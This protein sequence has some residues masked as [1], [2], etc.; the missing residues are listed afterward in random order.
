[1]KLL[2]GLRHWTP[3]ALLFGCLTPALLPAQTLDPSAPTQPPQNNAVGGKLSVDLMFTQAEA[4]GVTLRHGAVVPGSEEVSVDG[5]RLKRGDDYTIDNDAGIV[6]LLIPTKPGQAVSVNYR[7]DASR[8]HAGE[9]V[10]ASNLVPFRLDFGGNG[11]LGFTLGM[12][13]AERT[14]DGSVLSSNIFGWKNTF[15]V[16]GSNLSGLMLLGERTQQQARSNFEYQAQTTAPD[17]GKSHLII[18]SLRGNLGGG[19]YKL[20]FQDISKNFAG[21]SAVTANGYDS[22]LANQLSK[23]KG[24]KRFGFTMDKV[25]LGSLGLTESYRTVGNENGGITWKNFGINAGGLSM[26]YTSQAVDP[27][28]NRFQDLAEANHD[29]LAKEAGLTRQSMNAAWKLGFGSLTYD[30]SSIDDT[31]NDK[32]INRKDLKLTTPKFNFDL[33]SQS[34]QAGF[35]R[36]GSLNDP[37]A[38]QWGKESGL[39]RNWLSFDS[40]LGGANALKFMKYDINSPTGGMENVDASFTGKMWSF[41]HIKRDVDSGFSA[42]PN[43]TQQEINSNIGAITN[44]YVKGGLPVTPDMQ[45]LYMQSPGIDRD[46]TRMTFNPTPAWNIGFDTLKFRGK[47][48]DASVND[49][50][51]KGGGVN[52]TY[53]H[54]DFGPNFNELTHLMPFEQQRLGTMAGLQR[55]DF[56]FNADMRK[57]AKLAFSQTNASTANGGMDRQVLAYNDKTMQLNVNSRKVGPNFTTVGQLLDPEAAILSQMIGFRE[58]DAMLNWQVLSNLHIQASSWSGV[59]DA[60][61]QKRAASN[62]LVDWGPN[63]ATQFQFQHNSMDSNNPLDML[64]ANVLQRMSLTENLGKTGVLKYTQQDMQFDGTQTTQPDSKQSDLSY[65]TKLNATTSMKTEQI[66]TNYSDGNHENVS[67][68]TINTEL[69]KKA[70]LS[71]TDVAIQRTGTAPSE[72]KRNVGFWMNLWN[73]VRLNF[74]VND[75]LN[76]AGTSLTS[77][78]VSLSPGT[79]GNWNIGSATYLANTWQQGDRT[80]AQSNISLNTVKPFNIG[81]FDDL[82]LKMGQDTAADN[83]AWLKENKTLALAGKLGKNAFG[84]SYFGQMNNLHQRGADRLFTFSTDQSVTSRFVAS[85]SYKFRTLPGDQ[86]IAI[87]NFNITARPWN[88]LEICN[89]I[90]TNPEIPRGDVLLGSLPQPTRVNKWSLNYTRDPN[91]KVS[92]SWEEQRNDD[93]NGLT[94]LGGV[95]LTMFE[96]SGSPVSLF[97]GVEQAKGNVPDHTTDRWSLRWDQRPGPNQALSLFIGNITYGGTISPGEKHHNLSVD[98]EYQYRFGSR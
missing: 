78:T 45:G 80:Q 69:S 88:G 39:T 87:R 3:I 24:L 44:M 96:K 95:T 26:N 38:P 5:R 72:R 31:S 97:V 13:L 43:I 91:F 23:E 76:D 94:R 34:V 50:S 83:G 1:M 22:S 62:L 71:L 32:G 9:A 79:V 77:H 60:L 68:N 52:L 6:Y 84:Y 98:F 19:S 36:F 66:R 47:T 74:G 67:A 65:E 16:G 30:S 57:G 28:F 40:A 75:N 18:Q 46:F 49:I 35:A 11:S 92:G 33:G 86:N 61:T 17:Q 63:K 37:E 8:A 73:G 85:L 90:L 4:L 20:D 25:Q 82:T 55:T 7:Y 81:P 54:E 15:N 58:T 42:L 70:G 53:R 29:Q 93:T 64:L 12:G 21:F 48:D 41:E 56:A 51:M 89:Q 14:Q 10:S 59:N 2:M 27:H